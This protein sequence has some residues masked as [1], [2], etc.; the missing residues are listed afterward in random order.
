M[1]RSTR[2]IQ[3]KRSVV[4]A[5]LTIVFLLVAPSSWGKQKCTHIRIEL[6][7][8]AVPAPPNISLLETKGGTPIVVPV[9]N[10]CFQLPEKLQHSESIDVIFQV[11]GDTIHL[12]GYRPPDFAVGWKIM[13]SDSAEG[14]FVS[15]KGA[16]KNA[17]AK[18]VCVVEFEPGGDGTTT[19]QIGCRSAK[20]KTDHSAD[21]PRPPD[22]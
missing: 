18:G 8:A 20:K 14:P 5:G 17:P 4:I 21:G 6:N 2:G 16:F 11:G 7:G 1:R 22:N 15:F 19:V 10:G 13:L 12:T 3:I 9:E